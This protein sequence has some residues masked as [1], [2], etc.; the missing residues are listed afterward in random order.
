MR[1]KHQIIEDQVNALIDDCFSMFKPKTERTLSQWADDERIIPEGTS[2]EPGKWKTSRVPFMRYIMDAITTGDFDEFVFMASSQVGKTE[3][4]LNIL[5]FFI[6]EDPSPILFIQPT[7]DAAEA[8][9]EERFT[10]MVDATPCLMDKIAANK[11]RDGKNTTNSKMFKGG[12]LAFVGANV[13][14]DVSGRPR[15]IV[16]GDEID[17]WAFSAGKDGDVADLARQRVKNFW[18]SLLIWVSTPVDIDTSR[19]WQHWLGSTQEHKYIVCPCC[20]HEHHMVWENVKWDGDNVNSSPE[21]AY[22]ECPK[23]KDKWDDVTR[24][25]LDKETDIWKSDNPDSAIAG[26]HVNQL[27]SP[28]VRLSTLV[29]DFLKAK[30]KPLRE[31]VFQNTVLGLPFEAKLGAEVE[32]EDL[33]ARREE[34]PENTMPERAALLTA[35]VDIGVDCGDIQITAYGLNN[36]TWALDKYKIFGDPS[37]QSFWDDLYK[38]LSSTQYKHPISNQFFRIEATAID[39]GYMTTNVYKNVAKWQLRGMK[40][41]ATKG[42]PGE[43]KPLWK[44]STAKIK[45]TKLYLIGA[46]DAKTMIYSNLAITEGESQIHFSK[47]LEK[48]YFEE[49]IEEKIELSINGYGMPVKKWVRKQGAKNEAFDTM[50]YSWAARESLKHVNI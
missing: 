3:L 24:W 6:A 27:Y 16:L 43:G 19:I 35:G 31:K 2:P 47:R 7:K 10:P 14:Q 29:G 25:R 38:S 8:F 36:E 22:Y 15:R 42:V 5:A 39:S 23:C 21:T 4:L 48:D 11:S 46:D 26:W 1:Q 44:H 28:W 41:Y 49:L 20:K 9:S 34:I 40:V 45:Y 12:H 13:P 33:M 37:G 30:G 50:I 17:R 18:N 32:V